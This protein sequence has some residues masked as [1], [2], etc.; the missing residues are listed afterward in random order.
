[1]SKTNVMRWTVLGLALGLAGVLVGCVQP[2]RSLSA[3]VE[4]MKKEDPEFYAQLE[5]ERIER[6]AQSTPVE[7]VSVMCITHGGYGNYLSAWYVQEFAHGQISQ[8]NVGGYIV[9]GGLL[10][11]GY[12]LPPK[13][14]PNGRMKVKVRWG[15]YSE[16]DTKNRNLD[17]KPIW[18]EKYTTILPYDKPGTLYVHFFPGNEVRIVS[19]DVGPSNPA[20]PIARNALVPP[21][22]VE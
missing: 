20:H 19:S 7:Y 10:A 5:K 4:Q 12:P 18:H 17:A 11:L 21:P 13:W 14:L 22:E 6:R 3:Y 9:C 8:A 15:T 1:M 2:D 16:E